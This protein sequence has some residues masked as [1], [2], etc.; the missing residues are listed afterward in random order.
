MAYRLVILKAAAEDTK[1]L[2]TTMKKF[3][4]GLATGF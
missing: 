4:P 1:M 2:M 3:N